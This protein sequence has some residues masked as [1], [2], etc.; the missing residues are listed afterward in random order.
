MER[1]LGIMM[2]GENQMDGE[3]LSVLYTNTNW[4]YFELFY[5]H[6]VLFLVKK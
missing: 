2:E 5:E 4:N 6:F 1:D 3:E